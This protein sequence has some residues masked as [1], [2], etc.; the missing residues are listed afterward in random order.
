MLKIL[1]G[2]FLNYESTQLK[3]YAKNNNQITTFNYYRNFIK[4]W[5]KFNFKFNTIIRF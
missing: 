3:F 5:Y 1:Y 4:T 2:N